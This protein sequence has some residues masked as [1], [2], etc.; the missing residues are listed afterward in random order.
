MSQYTMLFIGTLLSWSG[1]QL[2]IYTIA[3]FK[4]EYPESPWNVKFMARIL[5]FLS[6]GLFILFS[7]L[8]FRTFAA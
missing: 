5:M 2:W 6:G 4:G 7:W 1:I 3:P 8:I